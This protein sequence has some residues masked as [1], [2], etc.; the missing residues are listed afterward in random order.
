MRYFI[1]Y[2]PK[3]SITLVDIGENVRVNDIVELIKEKFDLK[4][5]DSSQSET[6][7]VLSYN[8]FDLKPNWCF[9]DLS[10]P[11][12]TMIH[13]IFREEK[14][15]DLYVF[16]GF[17]KKIEKLFDSSITM[18]TY[19]STIRQQISNKLGLPLSTFCLETYD[20]T[21]RLYDEMKLINYDIKTHDHVYLKVWR[22]YEK[23]I[24]SCVKGLTARYSPDELTRHYQ[25][26]VALHIAAFYGKIY[27]FN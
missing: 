1:Y 22:G 2:P 5:H 26:Q 25:T 11:S 9:A 10:I 19:I 12:G 6:S 7:M 21:Q 3:K 20:G 17:N 23:F 15:A 16:C 13:F 14:A 18:E 4:I 8:G 24:R 27:F